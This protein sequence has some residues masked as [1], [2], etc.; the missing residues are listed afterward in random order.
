LRDFIAHAHPDDACERAGLN[1]W[2]YWVGEIGARQRDDS[3]MTAEIS[4][5]RGTR[6]LR[7]LV[8]RL[9]DTHPFI[10]LN[11]HSIWALL[12]ARRGIAHDDVMTG[13]A[14][15]D[16]SAMLLDSTAISEQSKRELASIV[17][18][19]RTD[20]LIGTGAI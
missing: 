6:L 7:H 20:G 10:D 19:L 9:D 13:R 2:A 4:T 3:F 14:L 11:V 17:Y 5:W 15:L 8:H 18:S 16:R 12:A 1:Y